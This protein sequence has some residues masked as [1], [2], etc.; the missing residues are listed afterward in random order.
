MMTI[1]R[2]K[3]QTMISI[4]DRESILNSL[5][6]LEP[7][8]KPVFG[9]M[10]PQHMVEHLAFTV[11]FSNGTI[12]QNLAYPPEIAEK[13]KQSLLYR[14]ADIPIGFKSP[15]LPKEGLP[16]L[17]FE[18]LKAALEDLKTQLEVFDHYFGDSPN[19]QP[20]NPTMGKL[21]YEEWFKFHNKH[22]AHH[23]KQFDLL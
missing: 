17:R 16:E 1:G 13:V 2:I 21:T 20:I 6:R 4:I 18:D 12:Q 14:G 10:T 9:A 11:A 7:T 5:N 15:I 23:F 8:N 22:F 19:A 3:I